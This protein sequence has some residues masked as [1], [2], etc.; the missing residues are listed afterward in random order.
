MQQEQQCCRSSSSSSPPC[1]PLL[2]I[3]VS[4]QIKLDTVKVGF[5]SPHQAQLRDAATCY[6]PEEDTIEVAHTPEQFMP[7]PSMMFHALLLVT[8]VAIRHTT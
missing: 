4:L 7:L 6:W 8:Q 2:S 3:P 5:I 1:S